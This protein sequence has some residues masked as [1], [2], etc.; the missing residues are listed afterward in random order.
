M[1]SAPIFSKSYMF[2]LITRLSTE[3]E[4]VW[5]DDAIG[6]TSL[7]RDF[8]FQFKLHVQLLQDNLSI[9]GIVLNDGT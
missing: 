8:K 4:M 5:L 1:G 2:K 6:I 3:S 9:I 7:L